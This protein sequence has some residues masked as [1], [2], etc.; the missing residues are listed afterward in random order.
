MAVWRRNRENRTHCMFRWRTLAGILMVL[1]GGACEPS[2]TESSLAVWDSAGTEIVEHPEGEEIT[3]LGWRVSSEPV[4]RL[5]SREGG[6]P[7]EFGRIGGVV[8]LSDGAVVVLDELQS[9]LRFFDGAGVHVRTVGGRG[10]GP[11][12]FTAARQL[13]KIGADTLAVW[14]LQGRTLTYFSPTGEYLG[15]SGSL[16]GQFLFPDLNWARSCIT[17][18]PILPNGGVLACLYEPGLTRERGELPAEGVNRNWVRLVGLSPDAER[19]DT[20]RIYGDSEYFFLEAASGAIIDG[21]HRLLS[22]S[23]FTVGLDPP[24]IYYARNPSYEI[25]VWTLEGDLARVIRRR[26]ARRIASQQEVESGWDAALQRHDE[27]LRSRIRS[28][29]DV[30]DRVPAVTAL[31]TGPAGELWVGRYPD[32]QEADEQTFEV[33]DGQGRLLGELKLPD[34]IRVQ[35]V[36]SDHIVG[37]T[38]DEV[39][40]QYVEVFSLDRTSVGDI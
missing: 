35:E 20:L 39:G 2:S 7:D 24:R 4:L 37:I 10:D 29:V 31:L 33:F 18:L 23:H 12:E 14:D 19:I 22:R 15:E 40:V 5:G 9:E 11:G 3:P 26:G 32:M 27:P 17:G 38:V 28:I 25:E 1:L 8:R 34:R 36:G 13:V 6:G 16:V 30:P 21:T